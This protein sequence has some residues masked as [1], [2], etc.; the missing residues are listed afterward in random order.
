MKKLQKGFTLI[1]LMIVI[2]IIAILAAFA[3]PAYGDYTKRTYV[4]EGLNLAAGAKNGIVDAFSSNGVIPTGFNNTQAGLASADLITGQAVDSVTVSEKGVNRPLITI[5]YNS[6][7]DATATLGLAMDTT[8][9]N[10][11][12]RWACGRSSP[13]NVSSDAIGDAL[14]AT[15]T[16]LKDAWLPANCRT[17][18]Q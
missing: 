16:A 15:S 7:V 18:A 5:A 6:K 1:E 4:A 13:T 12:Y 8:V 3:I 10:G 9:G 11:S 14:G 17:G 2:A